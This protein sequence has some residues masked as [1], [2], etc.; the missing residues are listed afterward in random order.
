MLKSYEKLMSFA[1]Q[2]EGKLQN[3]REKLPYDY[4]AKVAF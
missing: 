2:S 3:L 1:V 4:N